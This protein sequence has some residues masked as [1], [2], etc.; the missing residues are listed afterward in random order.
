MPAGLGVYVGEVRANR[1]VVAIAFD[2]FA[3]RGFGFREFIF[4][5]IN[6]AKAI[7]IS[8]AMRLLL[9]RALHERLRFIEPYAEIAEHVAVVV[10]DRRVS[11][12]DFQRFLELDF[13][14][15]VKLLPFVDGAQQKPH[16][17]VVARF[18][19]DGFGSQRRLFGVFVAAAA[20]VDLGNIQINLAVRVGLRKLRTK[21]FNGFVGLAVFTQKRALEV[22]TAGSL[23]YFARASLPPGAP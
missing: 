1:G 6:P 15:V 19:G 5:E 20:F 21:N 10:E 18:A 16:H 11:R 23:G 9:Q 14:A 7:E 8:A 3:Q 13:G 4:A 2:G 17:L 22:R 12:I